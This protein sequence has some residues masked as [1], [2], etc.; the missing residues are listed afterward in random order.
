MIRTATLA[1]VS[2]YALALVSCTPGAPYGGEPERQLAAATI[3][4]DA[5]KVAQLMASGANPNKVVRVESDDESPWYLALSRVRERRPET[6]EIV[7]LILK[8]GANPNEAWGT[9]G[10]G[11]P[12]ESA[13]R[14][15][16]SPGPG[17][18]AGLRTENPMRLAMFHPV[19]DVVRALV[20]S[21][22]DPR[23]GESALVD[24]VEGGNAEIARILVDAGVDVNCRPGPNTPLVA[25]IEARNVAL[26]TYLEEHGAR[27]KP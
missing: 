25:A 23:T 8:A 27:E 26:M 2:G 21:G 12:R 14:R 9:S 15:F 13:W 10:T 19:P 1:V 20:A 22:F 17:R 11:R 3:A 24:A 4:G 18:R 5:S 16:F 6:V 7:R